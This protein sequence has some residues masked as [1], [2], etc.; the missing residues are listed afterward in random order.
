MVEKFKHMNF[1]EFSRY[2]NDRAADGR[3]SLRESL[4]CVCVID[5]MYQIKVKR[6]GIIPSKK[7]TDEIREKVWQEILDKWEG[8]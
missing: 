7:L 3:W 6:F 1:K 5:R 4:F 8:C 2:C